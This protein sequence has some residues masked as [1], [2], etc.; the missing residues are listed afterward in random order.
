[1]Q[2]AEAEF[3]KVIEARRL[4]LE[5]EY[6][7]LQPGEWSQAHY[8]RMLKHISLGVDTLDDGGLFDNTTF[9]FRRFQRQEGSIVDQWARE[10]YEGLQVEWKEIYRHT[11]G[12]EF[13][14]PH[15]AASWEAT[16]S[17]TTMLNNVGLHPRIL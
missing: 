6:H 2:Q 4:A 8:A 10:Q 14:W 5:A 9:L 16:G 17:L 13:V 11:P 15:A 7:D 1:M 12:D 3:A